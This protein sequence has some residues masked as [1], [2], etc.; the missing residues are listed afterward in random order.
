IEIN[1]VLIGEVWI[2]SGQSNMWWPVWITTTGKEDIASADLPKMRFFT[3]DPKSTPKPQKD[4]KG[5]W[6]LSTPGTAKDFSAVAFVFGREL[7]RKL[8]VPVG[9]INTNYSGTPAEA[10]TRWKIME[11][12]PDLK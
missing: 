9:L 2:C 3:V 6:E 11:D 10:W 4:C 7:H 8:D 5:K 12:D 1:D